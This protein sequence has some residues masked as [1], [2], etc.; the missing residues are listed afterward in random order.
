MSTRQ[1][2]LSAR[3]REANWSKAGDK[4]VNRGAVG[5]KDAGQISKFVDQDAVSDKP[6][7]RM[8]SLS[9]EMRSMTKCRAG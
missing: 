8:A 5:D 1:L 2:G 6:E 3:S 9:A 7:D 4:P